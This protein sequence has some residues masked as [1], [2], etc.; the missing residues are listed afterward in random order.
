[1][2]SIVSSRMILATK[3]SYISNIMVYYGYV[4]EWAELY[5][6][7]WKDSKNEWDKNFHII[8]KIIKKHKNSRWIIKPNKNFTNDQAMFLHANNAH[9][10]FRLGVCLGDSW[11]YTNIIKFISN[12]A[13]CSKDLFFSVSIDYSENSHK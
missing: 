13:D 9:H 7:L 2:E 10:Y 8:V 5:K 3:I 4:H 12:L 1:M 11:S 6:Q